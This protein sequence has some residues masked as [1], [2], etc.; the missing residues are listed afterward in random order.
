MDILKVI[1]VALHLPIFLGYQL[2]NKQRCTNANNPSYENYMGR[3]VTMCSRWLNSFEAFL[4]D[5]GERPEGTTLDRYP[6]QN[7]D[8]EPSNCRWATIEE[9]NCNRSSNRLLTYK[10]KT[11][12]LI[13]WSKELGI[14]RTTICM[15]LN[16]LGWSVEKALETP[17]RQTTGLDKQ[18]V[19]QYHNNG[20]KRKELANMFNV[21]LSTIDRAV[22]T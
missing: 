12:T 11:Q 10:G 6:D 2:N 18:L 4:T 9:Q 22:R 5:M 15:R 20:M 17:V 1:M 3:G 21:S 16:D 13:E 8:Y 14:K 19:K 7:G